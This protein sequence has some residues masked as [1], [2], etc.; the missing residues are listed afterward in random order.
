MTWGMI[1]DKWSGSVSKKHLKT[2]LN[3]ND[4]LSYVYI[5]V[6]WNSANVEFSQPLVVIFKLLHPITS[7]Q[8]AHI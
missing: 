1:F 8:W 4:N 3:W 7:R 6:D 5:F 2:L